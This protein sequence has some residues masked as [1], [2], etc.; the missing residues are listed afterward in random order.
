MC[1]NHPQNHSLLYP[2]PGKICPQETGPGANSGS[3]GLEKCIFGIQSFWWCRWGSDR[4]WAVH[5]SLT[6]F[7]QGTGDGES[8]YFPYVRKQ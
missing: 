1:L 8:G 7:T 6:S 4:R 2:G 3:A 5:T